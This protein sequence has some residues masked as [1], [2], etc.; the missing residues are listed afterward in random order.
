MSTCAAPAFSLFLEET[1][2]E[3]L[4]KIPMS[5]AVWVLFTDLTTYQTLF[6]AVATAA[7]SA[8]RAN[9]NL[10]KSRDAT[11]QRSVPSIS[12]QIIDENAR[13]L[14]GSMALALPVIATFSIIFLF[15]FLNSIGAILTALSTISG[16]FSVF[17]LLWPLGESLARRLRTLGLR[18]RTPG[19]LESLLISPLAATVIAFWLFT[20]HW[21]L[22]NF[23]GVALCVTFASLCKVPSLK[24][25]ATLFAG[26]F[27]Y[28]IFFVFL[29]DRF[30]GK[31][32]MVEVATSTPLNPASAIA[33]FLHLPVTPVKTLALPAKLIFPGKEG[34]HSI[35]GLGDII[36]PEVFLVF[37]LEMDL[38]NRSTP[39][40]NGF[41][42]RGLLAYAFGL[43]ASFFFS[44]AFQ[45]AQP[46]LLYIVPALIFPSVLLARSRG[47]FGQLWNGFV[48]ST[49]A[50]GG[51]DA[52]S[53]SSDGSGSLLLKDDEDSALL[54]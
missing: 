29:S 48:R 51:G 53:R 28:D 40:Y 25:S 1:V 16:F 10:F 46:A 33:D 17:F 34:H 15:F 31:N 11:S 22:N 3:S 52:S 9:S 21:T 27:V 8:Y 32:V 38:R 20:G 12:D 41:F 50:G 4:Q 13:V 30:F 47:Q 45:A 54:A 6:T 7:Y 18:S 39:L 42:A 5:A 23:I 24:V 26:L 49:D 37:L 36:L 19:T 14:G 44:F 43:L 35:L 2:R